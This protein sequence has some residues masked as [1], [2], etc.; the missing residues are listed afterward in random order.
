MTSRTTNKFSPE[1]RARAARTVLPM[2]RSEIADALGLTIESISRSFTEIRKAGP[3]R[4]VD[5]N[6]YR[7]EM[8][9]SDR[10]KRFGAKTVG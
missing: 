6:P 4:F 10:I 9:D 5:G 1:M 2:K 8:L 7:V 3:I